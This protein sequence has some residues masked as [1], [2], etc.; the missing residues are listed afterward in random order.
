MAEEVGNAPSK[1]GNGLVIIL[2]VLVLLM[3]I[4]MGVLAFLILGSSDSGQNNGQAAQQQSAP[5]DLTPQYKVYQLAE[6]GSAPQY[7]E[8]NFVVNFKGEG[9]AKYLA[10]D[11][12]TMTRFVGVIED[13]EGIRPILYNDLT[14]LLRMQTYSGVNSDDGAEEVRSKILS[15]IRKTVESNGINPDVIQDVFLTRIVTQ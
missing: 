9:K 2:L 6:P 13:M 11:T 12:K 1:G 10:V 4:G 3:M 7:F 8:M 14:M 15:Q 5:V